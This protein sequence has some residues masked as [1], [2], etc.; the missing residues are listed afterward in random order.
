MSVSHGTK[1]FIL[2]T[3]SLHNDSVC[4]DRFL[5]P[6]HECTFCFLRPLYECTCCS[7][8]PLHEC[9]CCFLKPLHECTCCLLKPMREC[10]CYFLKPLHECA[11]CLPKPSHVCTCRPLNI[12][13]YAPVVISNICMQASEVYGLALSCFLAVLGDP[14]FYTSHRVLYYPCYITVCYKKV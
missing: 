5:T 7:L 4:T 3:L 6:L 12:C 1:S 11:S 10:I 2:Y 8:K 13:I 14:C 9:A